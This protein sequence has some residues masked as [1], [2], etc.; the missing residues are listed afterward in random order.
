VSVFVG[1]TSNLANSKEDNNT[2]DFD[3]STGKYS[4]R[5][6]LL[7]NYFDFKSSQLSPVGGFSIR[8]KKLR[9][10]ATL[11]T[12]FM[13]TNN[14][15]NYLNTNTDLSKNYALPEGWAYFNYNLSKTKS[16]NG[17]YSRGYTLP[18]G[19]QLLPVENL[20][21]PLNTVVGNSNLDIG[22][23]HNGNFS[24]SNFNNSRLSG[25]SI[26]SGG[27]YSDSGIATTSIYDE[28]GKQKT[29]YVNISGNY[30][31]SLGGNWNKTV[32]KDLNTFKYSLSLNS[33]YDFQKGYTN[34]QLY[35]AQIKNISPGVSFSYDY[36]SFFTLR[37]S[38]NFTYRKT[39]YDNYRIDETSNRE[40]NFKIEATNYIRKQ[41][42]FGNDF[43]YNY[44]SNI[45]GG[46][47]KDF[48]LWNTSLS[49]KDKEDQW[50]FKV[51]VYDILNQNQSATRTISATS[52]VDAQ[53]T[54]LKRYG[55]FSITYKFKKFGVKL[56]EEK[57]VQKPE[58]K[59]EPKP[60]EKK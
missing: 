20:S 49:Y 46:F 34:A 21:N 17:Y 31:V 44:N 56:E 15:S 8:K 26:Y 19:Q 22:K 42:V 6:E 45:S 4:D 36:G 50:T 43:G 52:I 30:N 23:S 32:K 40:H 39:N 48:Y 37:P 9:M 58:Q 10:R 54:V 60:N 53:N 38:Y 35:S 24:F 14:H 7:S 16:L 47:K 12:Y 59:L 41:W 33:G 51:K 3:S 28:N 55:M 29:T 1:V 25:F 27:S 2:F 18:T 13:E 5:N 11:G 57:P